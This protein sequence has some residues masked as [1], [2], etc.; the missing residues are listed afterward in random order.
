[1][2]KTARVARLKC[3]L[4]RRKPPPTETASLV[5]IPKL[6]SVP[7]AGSVLRLVYISAQPETRYLALAAYKEP[8]RRTYVTGRTE[9]RVRFDP[10]HRA[11]TR[12]L[13]A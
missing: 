4:E 5:P 11:L 8:A 2:V 13:V 1:M 9:E 10:V 12:Y 6:Q 7:L 3:T